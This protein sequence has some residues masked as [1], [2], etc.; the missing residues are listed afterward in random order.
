MPIGNQNKLYTVHINPDH[1][2]PYE[3]AIFIA[4]GFNLYAFIFHG[5]WILYHRIWVSGITILTLMISISMLVTALDFSAASTIV[6][7]YGMQLMVGFQ[8]NDLRR[9]HLTQKG[10]IL[11][12][13]VTGNSLLDAQ[14][15]FLDR[16]L[17]SPIS[18][19]QSQSFA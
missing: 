19:N 2:D 7:R 11:T 18:T 15:R 4:E 17:T 13:V 8:G 10:Y 16:R 6:L 12:D 3:Q 5:L 9:S 1:E 14:Q